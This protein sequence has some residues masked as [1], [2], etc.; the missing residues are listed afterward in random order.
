MRTFI[1]G[2][3]TLVKWRRV[4]P[5]L[6]WIRDP[7]LLTAVQCCLRIVSTLEERFIEI[8]IERGM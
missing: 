2:V 3:L 4:A 6:P 1:R 5:T 7:Y 8:Y